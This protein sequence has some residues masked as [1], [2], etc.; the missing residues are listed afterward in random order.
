MKQ[1]TITITREVIKNN[2]TEAEILGLSIAKE[3]DGKLFKV[4]ENDIKRD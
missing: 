2:P 4:V 1:Y 3:I